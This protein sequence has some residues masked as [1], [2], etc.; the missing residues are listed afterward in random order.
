MI[1][2]Y[3]DDFFTILFTFDGCETLVICR[4]DLTLLISFIQFLLL[5]DEKVSDICVTGV[6]RLGLEGKSKFRTY[7][8]FKVSFTL[9]N[10]WPQKGSKQGCITRVGVFAHNW[11]N[12]CLEMLLQLLSKLRQNLKFLRRNL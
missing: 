9:E 2:T 11:I 12:I 1:D 6:V 4:L 8:L 10:F 5:R 7:R 3:R